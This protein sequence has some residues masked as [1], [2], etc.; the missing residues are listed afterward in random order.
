MRSKT[1]A[2]LLTHYATYDDPNTQLDPL[3]FGRPP[4]ELLVTVGLE[5]FR[6]RRLLEQRGLS[7]EDADRCI[8]LAVRRIGPLDEVELGMLPNMGVGDA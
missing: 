2:D 3:A 5:I 1:A 4:T 7:P 8:E 6:A